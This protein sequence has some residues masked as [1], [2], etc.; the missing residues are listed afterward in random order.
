MWPLQTVAEYNQ[1]ESDG[2]TIPSAK[3]GPDGCFVSGDLDEPCLTSTERSE[4][5]LTYSR[6]GQIS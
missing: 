1:R 5:F 4:V 2:L 3:I 6:K